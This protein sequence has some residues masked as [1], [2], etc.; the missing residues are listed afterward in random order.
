ME[1]RHVETCRAGG[2]RGTAGTRRAPPGSD[3][4]ANTRAA[5]R[6]ARCFVIRMTCSESQYFHQGKCHECP[7]CAPGQELVQECSY[8]SGG[9]AR[10]TPCGSRSYKEGWGH[11]NCRLC[12]SC[13]R[14]N[15]R[16]A[17]PC[18]ARKNSV[19]GECLPG[20]YSKT[21]IDGAVDL[22][23]MPCGPL[24]AGQPQC[25]WHKTVDV[26][27]DVNPETLPLDAAVPA[28]FCGAL[29]TVTI[30]LSL[31]IFFSFRH[32]L[33]KRMFKGSRPLIVAAVRNGDALTLNLEKEVQASGP[34]QVSPVDSFPV[35]LKSC[36]QTGGFPEVTLAAPELQS[37]CPSTSSERRPLVRTSTCSRCSCE[38]VSRESSGTPV[39]RS[40]AGEPLPP[41]LLSVADGSCASDQQGAQRHTP[42]ECTEMDFQNSTDSEG[43]S[44]SAEAERPIPVADASRLSPAP[45][46]VP[47]DHRRPRGSWSS[48]ITTVSDILALTKKSCVQMQG[49][50]LGTLP[51][52]LV[53]LLA[54]KLDPSFPGVK[55]YQQVALELGVPPAVVGSLRGFHHVFQFA[56]SCTLCTVPDLIS[57]FYNLQRFDALLLLCEYAAERRSPD[58]AETSAPQGVSA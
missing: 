50:H 45:D 55:N 13:G 2:A 36:L 14:L 22:E 26:G 29:V 15:R 33:L 57:T 37:R 32:A 7:Q 49:V 34:F 47:D 43:G 5:P 52:A 1:R 8:G 21:R 56:S 31:L 3:S 20:F 53:D 16:Q 25:A 35:V 11:H 10:C 44:I 42:V 38:S 51:E 30:M 24:S 40:H 28:A 9:D 48:Y 27:K 54:L 19:C 41:P 12:T 23:C 17:T 39:D 46:R 4:L 18:S 58:T 6:A